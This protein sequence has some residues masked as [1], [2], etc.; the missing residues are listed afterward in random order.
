MKTR[1]E[2]FREMHHSQEP[3]VL[4]NVW[5]VSSALVYEKTGFKAL[6]TSSAAVAASM[7]YGDGE[8]MP[9]DRY[10]DVIKSIQHAV[11]IPL[12]VDLESGY[13]DTA[14]AIGEHIAALYDIGIVGINLE[15]SRMI[16]GKR[17]L[18][19]LNAFEEKLEA[20][21][22]FLRIRAIDVFLNLRCD[23]FLLLR[24]APLQEAVERVTCYER[25]GVDG[26]FLPCI[27][28][29]VDIEVILDAI[30]VPL[31]VMCIPG[32]MDF[33]KL[34]DLGVKRISMGS[35]IHDEVFSKMEAVLTGFLKERMGLGLIS[36]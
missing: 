13:G 2:E 33:N 31:N 11:S 3:L 9:F 4:G 20:I 14:E 28:E 30:E 23:A 19:G 21:V 8:K 17:T 29:E 22:S 6:G 7:G 24:E 18:Q 27:L 25:L 35:V 12:S 1:V 32:L 26:I 16:H 36:V 34:Q 5:D 15:D 10:Y